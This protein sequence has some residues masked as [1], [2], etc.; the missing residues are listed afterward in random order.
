MGSWRMALA[1][2]FAMVALKAQVPDLSGTWQLNVA[3]SSWGKHT[4]P[5]SGTVVIEHH[6]PHLKYSGSVD[7]QNGSE[8]ADGRST[9][10]FD[11]AIDG[12]EYPVTGIVGAGKMTIRRVSPTT[13]VS[14]LKSSNGTVLERA[15]TI[16]SADGKRLVRELKATTPA[17]KS[18]G[19]KS[20][21]A[22]RP[23]DRGSRSGGTYRFLGRLCKRCSCK[24]CS[25]A[26]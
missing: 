5:A 14:E 13:I 6:E 19:R 7:V 15:K 12:K 9:F 1:L 24:S 23:Y 21:T 2:S 25:S 22:A 11:G 8:T 16:I 20:T 3:K 4:K 26:V 18:P 10:S 17:V